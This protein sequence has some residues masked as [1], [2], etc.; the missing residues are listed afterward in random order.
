MLPTQFVNIREF[1]AMDSPR[2]IRGEQPASL[3]ALDFV[4]KSRGAIEKILNGE[5]S[6]LI[7]IVGPCSI[8]DEASCLEYARRLNDLSRKVSDQMLVVMRVFFEKPRTAIGWKGLIN[9]PHLDN[10]FN[11]LEGLRISRRILLEVTDLGLP[12]A[13]EILEPVTPLYISDLITVATIGART[14]ES[15]THRQM[16]SGLSMPVGHKNG[17]DGSLSVALDAMKS[18]RHPHSFVGINDEGVTCI[19]HTR[20]NRNVFPILRGG[21][22]GPNYSAEQIAEAAKKMTEYQLV[23][24]LMVDCSHANSRK[25]YRNQEAVWSDVLGQRLAGNKAII[26]MMLESHLNPGR[27]DLGADPSQLQYGVSITDGCIGWAETETL[28][29]EAHDKLARQAS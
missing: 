19:V 7:V 26:G 24:R 27:Q 17:T 29:L 14:T 8:H 15:P 13:T 3:A 10:S 4:L 11:I 5:D 21:N 12:A 9:D 6:R 25:D 28:M 23:P 18:A 1:V 2:I 22:S 20:G 16:A